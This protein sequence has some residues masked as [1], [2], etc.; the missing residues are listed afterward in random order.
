MNRDTRSYK[1]LLVPN[2]RS[3]SIYLLYWRTFKMPFLNDSERKLFES[4]FL[5]I[6]ITLAHIFSRK[7]KKNSGQNN[8]T[9]EI[10]LHHYK[11]LAIAV[12]IAEGK[13]FRRF[14]C[15]NYIFDYS[16]FLRTVHSMILIRKIFFGTLFWTDCCASLY[17]TDVSWNILNISAFF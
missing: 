5:L 8:G 16:I 3:D 2:F 1:S 9:E 13:F 15:L 12:F 10:S 4:T 17:A 6:T 14:W 7:L 11:T